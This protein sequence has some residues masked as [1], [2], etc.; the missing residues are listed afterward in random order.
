V[1]SNEVN[2]NSIMI[3]GIMTTRQTR[4]LLGQVKGR[5]KKRSFVQ[6]LGKGL[7]VVG[8][9]TLKMSKSVKFNQSVA[10]L[11]GVSPSMSKRRIV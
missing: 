4:R 11:Y 9:Q 5:T 3:T 10:N 7:L 2:S 8:K 6:K 1:N